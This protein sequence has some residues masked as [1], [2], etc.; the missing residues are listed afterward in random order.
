MG[1]PRYQHPNVKKTKP[2]EG[3]ARWYVRFRID[4]LA[5]RN[6]MERREQ[7]IY[8]GFCDE[9]SEKEAKKERD[10]KLQTVNNTPLVIQS[11]VLFKDLV[12]AYKRTFIPGLKPSA[13]FAK[14]W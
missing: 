10:H 11:Q 2:K 14:N 5:D 8:L 7:I 12:D 6:R 1:R 13:V 3:R 9:I 4:V